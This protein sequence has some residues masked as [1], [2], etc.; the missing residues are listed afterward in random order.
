MRGY[1]SLKNLLALVL[2]AAY[3]AAVRLGETTNLTLLLHKAIRAAKH[4]FGAPDFHYCATA[5][6]VSAI[7]SCASKGPLCA[8]AYPI[9]EKVLDI[10]PS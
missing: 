9:P 6:G 10:P 2:C 7:L 3:F 8:S 1:R 5:D 4:I